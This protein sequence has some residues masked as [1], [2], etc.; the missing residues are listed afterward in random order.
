M[1]SFLMLGSPLHLRTRFIVTV[2]HFFECLLSRTCTF[3]TPYHLDVAQEKG[4]SYGKTLR[5]SKEAVS[6]LLRKP[7]KTELRL[8]FSKT[9]LLNILEANEVR[10]DVV[11]AAC[12]ALLLQMCL[13]T[14]IL[15]RIKSVVGKLFEAGCRNFVSVCSHASQ[16]RVERLSIPYGRP[17]EHRTSEIS[18]NQ[19]STLAGYSTK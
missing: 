3:A 15:I 4:L 5:M 6:V 13:F 17:R 11:R 9:E 16:Y 12:F 1:I 14:I 8:K 7:L 2:L 10:N 18:R 19:N